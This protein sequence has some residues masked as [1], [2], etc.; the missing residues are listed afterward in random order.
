MQPQ[1]D[2]HERSRQSEIYGQ[3][4]PHRHGN[5]RTDER[6]EGK[7]GSGPRRAEVTQ[8]QHEQH[9]VQAT[10]DVFHAFDDEATEGPV[11]DRLA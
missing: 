11:R 3:R 2:A 5:D 1:T 4:F 9:V 10:Q 7:I 8:R 6:R